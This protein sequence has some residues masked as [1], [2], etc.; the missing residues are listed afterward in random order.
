MKKIFSIFLGLAFIV[1]SFAVT[2]PNTFAAVVGTN[3]GFELGANPG[4]FTTLVAGDST[5]ISGWA[6]GS[7]SVD[8]IG[9]YWQASDGTRSIDMNGSEAG[10]ISQTFPTVAGATYAVN[11]HLSGNPDVGP[12]AKV[13]RVSETSGT[14]ASQDYTYD[15]SVKGNNLAD[16]KW[17]SDTYT[18]VAS[19]TSTTL[20]FSSQN[21]G[22]AGPA[23]DN[24]SIQE[25]LPVSTFT[26]S[27]SAGAN[28][29][30]SPSG[31]VVVNS[32]A[33][34]TFAITANSGYH[35]SD[36]VVDGSSV[37]AVATYAFS[38]VLANHTISA[39]FAADT[40]SGSGTPQKKSECKSGGWMS[41]TK[42]S[43]RNQGQCVSYVQANVHAGKR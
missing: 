29:S 42:P 26:I 37:G 36:V 17:E 15:T 12:S 24:I 10:S 25:T 30:I 31:S 34:Q 18:F 23:L 20:T 11:F 28:G 27:S 9:S 6:V 8:Y 14:P 43:F 19:G 5:S 41:F 39:S 33:S 2:A 40:V 16:M 21:T 4:I 13:L 1:A 7:G 38:N 35:V 32:G 22:A 3:G